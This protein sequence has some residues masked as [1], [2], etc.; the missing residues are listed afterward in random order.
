[1]GRQGENQIL[2]RAVEL[3]RNSDEAKV[4]L[5]RMALTTFLAVDSRRALR[6]GPVRKRVHIA[7]VVWATIGFSALPLSIC[8]FGASIPRLLAMEG[9]RFI[10]FPARGDRRVCAMAGWV[11]ARRRGLS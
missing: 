6:D 4:P 5:G 9:L 1:M 3:I 11:S 10:R 7:D 8:A 2:S